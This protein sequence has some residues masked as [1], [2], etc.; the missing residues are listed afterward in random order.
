MTDVKAPQNS[1]TLRAQLAFEIDSWHVMKP[2]PMRL[3]HMKNW[4]V[5]ADASVDV[6]ANVFTSCDAVHISGTQFKHRRMQ[7]DVIIFAID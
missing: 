3:L 1:C 7:F 2:E 4:R 5:N 6:C